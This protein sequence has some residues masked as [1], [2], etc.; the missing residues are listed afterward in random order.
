MANPSGRKINEKITKKE[1]MVM[2]KEKRQKDFDKKSAE[3]K[4]KA[5]QGGTTS[6]PAPKYNKDGIRIF[7]SV[8][9]TSSN[10]RMPDLPRPGGIMDKAPK[11]KATPKATP[12]VKVPSMVGSARLKSKYTQLPR[13]TR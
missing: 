1:M 3:N 13:K 6:R 10:Q 4:K 2:M 11:A 12:K 9:T 5:L 7:S 8:G